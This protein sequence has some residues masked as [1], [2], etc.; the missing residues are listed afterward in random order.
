MSEPVVEDLVKYVYDQKYCKH[1]EKLPVLLCGN[2][3]TGKSCM[4]Q[5]LAFSM[6]QMHN[7]EASGFLLVLHLDDWSRRSWTQQCTSARDAGAEFWEQVFRCIISLAPDTVIKYS[8]DSI[9]TVIRMYIDEILFLIDWDI[10]VGPIRKEIQ[11]GTWV[12]AYHGT[13]APSVDWQI[14]RLEPYEEI[15]VQQILKGLKTKHTEDVVRLYEN[16]EYKGILT[17][18]DMIKIFSEMK[19]CVTTGTD[20]EI[21]EAYVSKQF[22]SL[23]Y[24]NKEVLMI[25]LGETAF[26]AICRNRSVFRDSDLCNVPSEVKDKFLVQHGNS[27]S[28]FIHGITQDFLASRY[29]ISQPNKACKEWLGNVHAL[30]RVFKFACSSWC[31]DS[32]LLRENLHHIK[33]YLINLFGIEGKLGEY[34]PCKNN[35]QELEPMEVDGSNKKKRKTKKKFPHFVNPLK[36]PFTNWGF[37]IHLDDA[38]HGR[39]E[40]LELLAHLLSQI[41][42]WLFKLNTHLD[43]GKLRRIEKILTKVKLRKDCPLTIKLESTGDTVMP[44]KIWNK[45]RNIESL[46]ECAHVKITVKCNKNVPVVQQSSVAELLAMIARAHSPLYIT[47]YTGPFFCS[48]IPDFLKCWSMR[49]LERIDVSVY[50]VASLSEVMSCKGL[51]FLK[52]VTV[53]V[54]LRK[55]EQS[56]LKPPSTEK[57]EQA[58]LQPCSIEIPKHVNLNLSVI[59]FANIQNLLDR[60]KSPHRLLSLSIH[61]LFVEENFRLDLSSFMNL[62]SLNIR[63]E[64]DRGEEINV[65]A[66]DQSGS[67]TRQKIID[68]IMEVDQ[69]VTAQPVSKKLPRHNWMF[70]LV[71]NL[72]LPTRLERLLLRN[73]EFFNSSNNYMMLNLFKKHNIDRLVILDSLL[74]LKGARQVLSTHTGGINEDLETMTKRLRVDGSDSFRVRDLVGKQPRLSREERENRRKKKPIGKEVIITSELSLCTACKSFPC[75][76]PPQAGVDNKDTFEDLIHLIEDIYCYDVLSFTYTSNILTVRK[77]L[78]GDLR[79]HCIVTE[80]NDDVACGIDSSHTWLSDFFMTLTLAQCISFDYTDLSSKGAMTVINHLKKVKG[81]Q[82]IDKNVEPFSL[83]IGSICHPG[84]DEVISGTFIEFIKKEDCLAMFNFWCMCKDKCFKLKKAHSGQ[85]LVNDKLIYHV[86]DS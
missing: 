19:S 22:D 56:C 30:K 52:D 85:I 63:C 78:C 57:P 80:L 41:P 8:L 5:N 65:N 9:K 43:D 16:F 47:Q 14:L 84:S 82:G 86:S 13:F 23:V 60:F 31:K 46:H 62:E 40:I 66:M 21:A 75:L 4:L 55:A 74:S 35:K 36:D 73:M 59:Y 37:I 24:G 48:E 77:D 45:L 2:R 29:V 7:I 64:P 33:D 17:S 25:A 69:A 42:C 38:C 54:D 32:T 6:S 67:D 83:T 58:C 11:R 27:G 61:D 26:Y 68:N 20:F 15:Q 79:V 18:I 3:G 28:T 70:A 34:K 72:I 39:R 71:M 81:N 49:K 51:S 53:R 44:I 50:D 76:C 10:N 12:V 1:G